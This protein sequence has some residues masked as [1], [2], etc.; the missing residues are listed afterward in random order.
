VGL[1]FGLDT[2]ARE[3]AFASAEDG[4]P[5]FQSVIRHYTD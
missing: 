3:N 2:E 1:R 4:T 5:V